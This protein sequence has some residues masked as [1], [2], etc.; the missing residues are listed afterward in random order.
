MLQRGATRPL[1]L[2]NIS[3][4][5]QIVVVDRKSVEQLQTLMKCAI[6]TTPMQVNYL[7]N[8]NHY[9]EWKTA[10]TCTLSGALS[11]NLSLLPGV[12]SHQ[13]CGWKLHRRR[14]AWEWGA[15]LGSYTIIDRQYWEMDYYERSE[16]F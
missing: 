9:Y 1:R 5:S 3:S 10:I 8:F 13:G 15:R 12:P 2:M 4:V 7:S 11:L 6:A 16:K 14:R